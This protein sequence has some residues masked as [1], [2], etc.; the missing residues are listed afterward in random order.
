M[1]IK[2]ETK[3]RYRIAKQKLAYRNNILKLQL[4]IATY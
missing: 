4:R 2:D 3:D 1:Y